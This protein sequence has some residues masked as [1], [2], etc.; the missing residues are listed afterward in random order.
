MFSTGLTREKAG[1]DPSGLATPSLEGASILETGQLA[2]KSKDVAS[3]V[4]E[5][6]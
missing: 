1:I 2:N 3:H 4:E 6:D 5:G